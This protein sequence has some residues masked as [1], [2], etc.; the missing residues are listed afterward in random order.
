MTSMCQLV[1]ATTWSSC[2]TKQLQLAPT[3]KAEPQLPCLTFT[4][5][6]SLQLA[7]NSNCQMLLNWAAAA[8]AAPNCTAQ[9]EI[10]GSC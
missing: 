6:L 7:P 10:P 3:S 1:C 9:L 4:S 8:A 5:T 2:S